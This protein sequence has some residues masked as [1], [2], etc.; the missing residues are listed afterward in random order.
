MADSIHIGGHY[1]IENLDAKLLG[2]G[3]MGKVYLGED[4]ETGGKVAIKTLHAIKT[5]NHPEV[6]ERF[7]REGELLRTL[8]H[9][10]IVK[11]LDA[12]EV[13]GEQY[14]VMEYV[15]GGDLR[16]QLEKNG[17][18]PIEETLAIA[19]E[20]ADAL[21][22]AHHLD[23]IHRDIKPANVL[24]AKDNTPRLTDFGIAHYEADIELTA[25]GAVLGTIPYLSPEG[26]T[27]VGLDTRSDVWSFGVLLYEILTGELPFGGDNAI[28]VLNA[29]MQLDLPDIQAVRPD[30]PDALADLVYR[31]LVKDP[32]GRI[33]SVRLVGAELEGIIK[34][35]KI[36]P[37]NKTGRELL[38]SISSDTSTFAT[39]EPDTEAKKLNLP[40][41]ATHFVGR[42]KE[43]EEITKL[44][45][46]SMT[47]LLTLLGPGG[48]GKTRLAI[49]A[50]HQLA[51]NYERGAHFVD[52][53]PISDP[54]HIVNQ[55]AKTFKLQIEEGKDPQEQI[56]F[57]FRDKQLLLVMDN[58]E[59]VAEGAV[60][61]RDIL[62][63]APEV[64][65]V[66]T[67]RIQLDLQDE[68][69]YEV[70]GMISPK[71]EEETIFEEIE[72]VEL[73]I[74]HARRGQPDYQLKE[75]DK[76]AVVNICQLVGGLPLGI[77]LAA[78]WVRTLPEREIAKQL[79]E[80]IDF[81][82]TNLKDLP[83][84]Q[85]S[86]RAA[87]DYSWKLLPEKLQDIY[88]KISIFRGGFTHQAAKEVAGARVRD[89]ANF[90]NQ[91]LLQRTSNGRFTVHELMRQFALEELESAGQTQS[92]RHQHSAHYADTLHQRLPDLKG[93]DQLSALAEI[94]ADFENILSAWGWS[95]AQKNFTHLGL[96]ADSLFLICDFRGHLTDRSVMF[97]QALDVIPLKSKTETRLIW[98]RLAA[99]NVLSSGPTKKN[100]E[101]LEKALELARKHEDAWGEA[102]IMQ[103]LGYLLSFIENNYKNS[104]SMYHKSVAGFDKLGDKFYWARSLIFFGN[105][106]HELEK[107]EL[108]ISLIQ[109]S[110]EITRQIGDRFGSA[111]ALGYIGLRLFN[112][113]K[114]TE[115]Q[116]YY[117][118]SFTLLHQ[119]GDLI[120]YANLN[121][122]LGLIYEFSGNFDE[123]RRVANEIIEIGK[124]MN[125]SYPIINGFSILADIEIRLENYD[126]AQ[127][128][129]EEVKGLTPSKH[130]LFWFDIL[131][132]F[133][134]L[135]Q[136]N[137]KAGEEYFYGNLDRVPSA[138]DK[139]I[140]LQL[141]LFILAEQE[142]KEEAVEI[143]S[144][145]ENYK[146]QLS[147]IALEGYPWYQRLRTELE[148]SLS[149]EE[150]AAAYERGKALELD[151]IVAG[152]NARCG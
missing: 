65:I 45:S 125:I 105:Q 71:D 10:N 51:P 107:E 44:L 48:M 83:P 140:F 145:I 143:M 108:G 126:K 42:T 68:H 38:K 74:Q 6:L 34:G 27:G 117:K 11:M 121:W 98:G 147:Q 35:F 106:S 81:L 100:K 110:L 49:E 139:S 152:I 144:F 24:L 82:E 23:I 103:A 25:A 79:A 131:Q 151:E 4:T 86:M 62:A 80:D 57:Y 1:R 13:D 128:I 46:Q 30:I 32:D 96:L 94:E 9:P 33:P 61:L 77:Q 47:R 37:S 132:G 113:G 76:S 52:L 149:P 123:S 18:L 58:F 119:L 101:P 70:S 88:P 29:I 39:P 50:A 134:S 75:A 129:F 137:L 138:V 89:L 95:L 99:Y 7:Q 111:R 133:L 90:V 26:C 102:L 124:E 16:D 8:D 78:G 64:N 116:S 63:E 55:I 118:E 109:Q 2:E 28:G 85:R 56:K 15:E 36:T 104:V 43:L 142:K 84:R 3:G 148:A 67:S 69:V 60:L 146:A 21:T 136:G 122:Q 93:G 87:F 72:A 17:A 120:P 127:E 12:L 20:L 150:H 114:M 19:L 14:L 5:K 59:H 73:F 92:V 41:Q 130:Y 53:A 141:W 115:A 66:V 135:A 112:E 31:M 22:R 97:Q 54:E 91:S 40:A